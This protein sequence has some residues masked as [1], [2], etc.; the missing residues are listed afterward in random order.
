ML[1]NVRCGESNVRRHCSLDTVL[2]HDLKKPVITDSLGHESH[3]RISN[4]LNN[5]ERKRLS[6]PK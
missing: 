3:A 4:I 5:A 2:V 6:N 1:S